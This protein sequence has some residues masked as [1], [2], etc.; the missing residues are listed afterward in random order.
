[1]LCKTIREAQ[2]AVLGCYIAI[3]I[4]NMMISSIEQL[5]YTLYSTETLGVVLLSLLMVTVTKTMLLSIRGR[6]YAKK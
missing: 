6:L 3:D 5:Y 1:M 4:V 2:I